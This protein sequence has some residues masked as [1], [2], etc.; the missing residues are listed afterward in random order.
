VTS[1][2]D[3]YCPG[4]GVERYAEPLGVPYDL[5]PGAGHINTDAGFGPWPAVE[6]WC[7][8]ENQGIET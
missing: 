5:L 7:Y 6:A 8:G 4:G 3:P 2:A 1:D